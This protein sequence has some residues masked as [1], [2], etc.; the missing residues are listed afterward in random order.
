MHVLGI[1][2]LISHSRWFEP[3][4][5]SESRQATAILISM[6]VLGSIEPLTI[7]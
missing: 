7:A 3:R 2:S 4:D 1:L 6:L 5:S